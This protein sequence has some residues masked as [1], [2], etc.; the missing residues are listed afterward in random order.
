MDALLSPRGPPLYLT[1]MRLLL[2]DD[3][4]TR[5]CGAALAPCITP[6]LVIFLSGDLGTGKTTFV[7]GLLGGCGYTGKVKSPTFSLVEPYVVSRLNFYHFDLYRLKSPDEWD[8]AGFREMF[9]GRAVCVVEWPE[10]AIARLPHNDLWVRFAATAGERAVTIAA[11][12]EQG[13]RCREQLA[14][15]LPA[16]IA[17]SG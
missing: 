7:R 12:T 2:P 1:P 5:A 13:K 15:H 10:K 4:A 11:A 8:D 16:H 6:G 17:R 14:G 3:T 9:D